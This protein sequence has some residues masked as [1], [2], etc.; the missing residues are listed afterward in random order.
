[1]WWLW[2]LLLQNDKIGKKVSATTDRYAEI[3]G[4]SLANIKKIMLSLPRSLEM[5]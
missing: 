1:M 3:C 2:D 4:A 5:K